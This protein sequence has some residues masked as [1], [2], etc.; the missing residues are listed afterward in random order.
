M[1]SACLLIF[2]AILW[3]FQGSELLKLLEG[4]NTLAFLAFLLFVTLLIVHLFKEQKWT[5]DA[6]KVVGGILVGAAGTSAT[7]VSQTAVGKNI[8]QAMRDIIE[9][10]DGDIKEL[11]D[12]V[13]N[14]HPTIIRRLSGDDGSDGSPP[15]IQRVAHLRVESTDP[16]FI[17]ELHQIQGGGNSAERWIDACI[18]NAEIRR[19]ID[20]ELASLRSDGWR[21]LGMDLDNHGDGLHINVRTVRPYSTQPSTSMNR[22]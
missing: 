18:D 4:K 22:G 14:Q 13:V 16:E 17:Q 20:T 10:V 12:S 5:E 19:K 9:R 8:K 6:L 2:A 21:I 7:G 15:L 3:K 11:R 1:L